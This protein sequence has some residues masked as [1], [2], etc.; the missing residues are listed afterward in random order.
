M[1][2]KRYMPFLLIATVLGVTVGAGTLFFK[3]AQPPQSAA[4]APAASSTSSTSTATGTPG[5]DPA[6]IRGVASAT[7]TLEEFGDFECPPCGALHPELKKIEAEYGPQ[8]RVVFRHFPLTKMHKHAFNAARAAE[9]AARQNRFWEMHDLLFEKQG[10]WSKVTDSVPVFIEYARNLKLDV[11]R[12]TRDMDDQAASK[13]IL[14]DLR[15]GESMG[16]TG[17]P[18]IFINNRELPAAAITPDGIRAAINNSLD[19]KT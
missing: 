17:T 18:S 11:A 3:S 6:H 9:A 19:G 4:Q 16:V 5:A 8:L 14:L 10:T 1:L 15:R 12:F 7:V 13:R 2:M